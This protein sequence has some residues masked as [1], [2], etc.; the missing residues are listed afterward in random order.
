[1]NEEQPLVYKMN[2]KIFKLKNPPVKLLIEE[3][4]NLL[5]TQSL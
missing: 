4:Y 5:S 3:L 2:K 1:M